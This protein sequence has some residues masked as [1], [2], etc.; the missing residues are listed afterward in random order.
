VVFFENFRIAWSALRANLMR[1][2]LTTIGIIIGVTA[3]IAV[4]SVIQGLQF[5]A[6]NMFE[7]V[8]AT[9]M[10]V[11]PKGGEKDSA[12][13]QV[14]HQVLLSWADGEA[15][16]DQV[17]GIKLITPVVDGSAQVKYLERQ[18][19]PASVQ[20]VNAEYP[21]IFNHT[22]DRGRFFSQIDQ[23]AGHK[24]AVIGT[25]VVE[26]L[27][28]GTDPIG[29]TIYIGGDPATI[30]GVMEEK[31]QSLGQDRDD[32]VF[33]PFATAPLLFGRNAVDQVNLNLQAVDTASIDSVREGIN[34]V[35]R[36]RHHL[37]PGQPDDFEVVV[38]DEILK[39][40]TNVLSG[41]TA[42]IG[43]VVAISL[44]VGGI[45]IM[46]IMLVSVTERTREIG[47]R[48]AVGARR[49]DVMLQFLIEA[50]TL[51]LLGGAIGLAL[52]YAV[53][54]LVVAVVPVHLPPAHV[55]AWA[56]VLSL[57]FSGGI[58]VIFGTYPASKAASLDP[59]EAL[60]FE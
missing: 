46:N 14:S 20:G 35:L 36:R 31:G 23:E 47:V 5:L 38:Q 10:I 3:V 51:S 30:V 28:L 12:P 16:R 24:V 52:G 27:H 26:E 44:L 19:Q 7:S 42:V 58:G 45:G 2:V 34:H 6:T 29:K 1:S 17:P 9:F 48:K 55:P 33:V 49:K 4:V 15:I 39:Q 60:R 59:I 50:V 53:G 56:I 8:G 57:G 54:V 21:D 22:V 32:V 37:A 13:G 40:I 43:G 25:K 41:V 18:H 11:T